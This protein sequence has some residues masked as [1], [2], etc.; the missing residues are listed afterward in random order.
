MPAGHGLLMQEGA[1]GVYGA[2]LASPHAQN[3]IMGIV[4]AIDLLLGSSHIG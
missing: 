3:T 4:Y 1:G 2:N